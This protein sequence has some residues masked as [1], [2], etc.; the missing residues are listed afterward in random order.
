MSEIRKHYF[1]SDY[2]IIAEERSKRPSDFVVEK[3]G[4]AKK[5][6]L[7]GACAF[8][9]GNEDSTPP[10]SAVYKRGVIFSDAFEKRVRDWDFRCFPN[11]Y[12]V[13]SPNPTF[14]ELPD[15]D[16]E[17]MPGFGF[18]E[19]IVESPSHGKEL[20]D[21][22]DEEI[23]RLMQVYRDRV[24]HYLQHEQIRH[25]SLFKNSGKVAGASLEHPHSQLIA[26]PLLPPMFERE[27]QAIRA[28]ENCP[29]C[30]I[31]KKEVQS[32]RIIR[33]NRDCIAFAPY[34]SRVPFEVWVLPKK[35]VCS[36]GACS[37]KLLFSLGKM[38]RDIVLK[39]REKLGGDVCGF[40]AYNCMFHLSE[41]PEYH[42]SLRLLP[43]LSH[44]AGFE[45][46]TNIYINTVSPEA[47]ASYLR[48]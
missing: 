27:L 13:L 44:T 42:L 36:P 3:P 29:Y 45:L 1:L 5:P 38:L 39:Y 24:C 18:H 4:N 6:S 19:V 14:S 17:T 40:P 25:V 8:C 16:W 7:S 32:E 15:F 2:C 21:F 12:P 30:S 22:S 31:L 47:A 10:A 20:C 46:N 34:C 11:R 35:H 23:S 41:T 26:L 37:D 48:N 43:R 9:A 28:R 33:E